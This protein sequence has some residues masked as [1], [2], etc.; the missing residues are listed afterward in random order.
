MLVLVN[1]AQKRRLAE[2]EK[3]GDRFER[4]YEQVGETAPEGNPIV[5]AVPEPEEWLLITLGAAMLGWL[6]WRR[7][8]LA[9]SART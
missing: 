5:T 9:Q 8:R 7:C 6:V 3:Q 1:E 4:E 2:L